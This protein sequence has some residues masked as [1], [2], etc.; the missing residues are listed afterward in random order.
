MKKLILLLVTP[1]MSFH[2]FADKLKITVDE[3]SE[4]IGGGNHNAL[5][6]TIYDASPDDIIKEWKSKMKDYNAKVSGKDEIFADNALIKEISDNTCDVYAKTE[7]VSDTE[8]KFIVGFLL[9]ETW[10]SSSN[11][12]GPY[13]AA[14]KIVK[15]FATKMTKDAI[16]DKLKAEQKKLDKLNDE[17]SDLE[18]KNKDLHDDIDT[19]NDKIKKAQDDI[20]TNEDAQTSKK[21]EIDAQQKA[22]DDLKARQDS[23]E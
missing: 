20:K 16:G 11:N 21:A 7:K 12:P 18:K 19:Y 15:D 8:T 14:E 4:N 2:L 9:G 13:K 6:V 5:V 23:V 10:L 1:L 22:V 17:Q 3:K